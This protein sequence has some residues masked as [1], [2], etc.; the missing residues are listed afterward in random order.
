MSLLA[1][2]S[3]IGTDVLFEEVVPVIPPTLNLTITPDEEFVIEGGVKVLEAILTADGDTVEIDSI[4]WLSSNPEIATVDDFGNVSGV[5]S[6]QTFVTALV[7]STLSTETLVNVI[8]SDIGDDFVV[9]VSIDA[10]ESF[11]M[12]IDAEFFLDADAINVD[13]NAIEGASVNFVSS[14]PAVASIGE[15]GL[16]TILNNGT[17]FITASSGGRNSLPIEITG[18]ASF[19]TDPQVVFNVFPSDTIL[20]IGQTKQLEAELIINDFLQNLQ[21]IDWNS[22]NVEIATVDSEGLV[23]AISPGQ[24]AL[25]ATMVIGENTFVSQPAILNALAEQVDTTEVVQ[26]LITAPNTGA[27][28]VTIDSLVQFSA[29]ALNVEGNPL[30]ETITWQSA[31]T[32]TA[33]ISSTGLLTALAEGTTQIT[34]SS[35]G[36]SSV[37]ITVSVVEPPEEDPVGGTVAFRTGSFR[38][39]NGYRVSGGVRVEDNGD[40][41]LTLFLEDDFSTS[42]GPSLFVYLANG[43]SPSEVL[44]AGF[45]VSEDELTNSQKSGASTF[46]IPPGEI[47]LDQFNEVVIYCVPFNAA[48]GAATLSDI[49]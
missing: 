42:R 29:V 19:E 39:L 11:Q 48:F 25:T 49:Q 46:N 24:A 14:N 15:N 47:D 33:S 21:S 43:T 23:E 17:A 4:I 5:S 13:G 16:I 20:T 45:Q 44:G 27:I 2:G 34:A 30:D 36:R 7:D 40:G 32:S 22:N 31:S 12:I 9:R 28:E 41:S 38:D 26:V 8:P 37:S 10:P 3:C 1:L 6:G 35:Q 18:V